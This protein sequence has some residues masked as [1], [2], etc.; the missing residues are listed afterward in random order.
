MSHQAIAALTGA[1]RPEIDLGQRRLEM[2]CL[3]VIAMLS[4]RSVN[5]LHVLPPGFH[6]IRHFGFLANGHRA[7]RLPRC[8][9]LLAQPIDIQQDRC[10]SEPG[11]LA[12]RHGALHQSPRPASAAAA[13]R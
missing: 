3:I 7:A 10:G 13:S 12:P 1:L 11:S 8:R 5:L 9:H 6:C 4:A 2:L